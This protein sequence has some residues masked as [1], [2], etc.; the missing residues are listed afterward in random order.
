MKTICDTNIWRKLALGEIL[1]NELLKADSQITATFINIDE[2]SKSHLVLTDI[3]SAKQTIRRIMKIPTLI[4]FENP[5]IYLAKLDNPLL[6]FD[7]KKENE[8]LLLT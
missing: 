2:I 1:E 3:E 8:I 4:I 7:I 6:E 5:M